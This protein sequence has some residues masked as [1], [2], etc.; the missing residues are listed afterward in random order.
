MIP[1]IRP[2]SN[3]KIFQ[4]KKKYQI[5]LSLFSE[6]KILDWDLIYL[7]ILSQKYL[8]VKIIFHSETRLVIWKYNLYTIIYNSNFK[9][10][11]QNLGDE[12]GLISLL[13]LVK[14]IEKDSFT[15]FILIR[16]S[17]LLDYLR[18]R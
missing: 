10:Y 2:V 15:I 14:Y 6:R 5:I 3:L 8:T 18:L 12:L 16:Y 11:S 17:I 7:S 9:H 4:S 13:S 1:N